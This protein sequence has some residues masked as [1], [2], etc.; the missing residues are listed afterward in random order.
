MI[1]PAYLVKGLEFEA[2]IVFSKIE[3]AF[4]VWKIRICFMF[5]VLEFNMN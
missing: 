2:V 3:K 4:I 1:I 5:L